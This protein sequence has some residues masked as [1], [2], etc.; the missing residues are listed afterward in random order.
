MSMSPDQFLASM[1]EA[2]DG[3][4]LLHTV[5]FESSEGPDMPIQQGDALIGAI[6]GMTIIDGVLEIRAAHRSHT[7]PNIVEELTLGDADALDHLRH[8]PT[9][10]EVL[11]VA[12]EHTNWV[13][14]DRMVPREYE[15]EPE[16]IKEARGHGMAPF[17]RHEVVKLDPNLSA[18]EVVDAT[19]RMGVF[20]MNAAGL[21]APADVKP[22]LDTRKGPVMIARMLLDSER[23]A[24]SVDTADAYTKL[25]DDLGPAVKQSMV[26]THPADL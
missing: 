9:H 20:A 6:R 25:R 12:R 26:A 11:R 17:L 1:R 8:D 19:L 3:Q 2:T 4:P 16:L 24:M 22:S 15:D 7:T 10:D 23:A 13:V 18:A 21:L 5:M 14:A